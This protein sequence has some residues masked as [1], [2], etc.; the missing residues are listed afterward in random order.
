M[1]ANSHFTDCKNEGRASHRRN[2]SACDARKDGRSVPRAKGRIGA[3]RGNTFAHC[4]E[5]DLAAQEPCEAWSEPRHISV[6]IER[7]I[8]DYLRNDP[9]SLAHALERIRRAIH[10]EE[11][12]RREG[13]ELERREGI[14]SLTAAQDDLAAQ[15]P[16]AATARSSFIR[17]VAGGRPGFQRVRGSETF[18][19]RS[20]AQILPNRETEPQN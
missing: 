19:D 10:Y 9:F 7:Q 15:E 6:L 13:G 17:N 2:G 1:H 5:D 18:A 14:R 11:L 20:I 12:E 3:S 16:W 8:D 4:C